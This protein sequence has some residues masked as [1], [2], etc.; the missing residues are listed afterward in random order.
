MPAS[1][2]AATQ[3]FYQPGNTH[4]TFC[5]AIA[6]TSSPLRAEL[7]AGTDLS[8]EVYEVSGFSVSSEL[9]DAPDFGSRQI[10]K[11]A[12]QITPADS[13]LSMYRSFTSSDVRA[14][15]TRDTTGFM[16]VFPEGDVAGKKMDVFP[17][18]VAAQQKVYDIKSPAGIILQ[19]GIT[20]KVQENLTVPA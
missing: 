2:I 15:L 17:V 10:Q 13:A 8:S 4:F 20:G 19:F 14:T 1:P 9:L 3:R 11:I 6:N 12:G 18:T 7:N 5:P 16:V